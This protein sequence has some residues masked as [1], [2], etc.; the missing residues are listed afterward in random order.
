M[1]TQC[2]PDGAHAHAQ[3]LYARRHLWAEGTLNATGLVFYLFNSSKLNPD[4]TPKLY[5]TVRDGRWCDCKGFEYRHVCA[6]SL[7]VKWAA[8][9]ARERAARK[10][11]Y[12]DLMTDFQ[13]EGTRELVDAF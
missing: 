13:R 2:T 8:D 1:A 11:S 4:G 12:D 3:T 9:E 10:A 5:H 6:H 7:A